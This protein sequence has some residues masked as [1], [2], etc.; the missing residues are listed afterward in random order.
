M[1]GAPRKQP[2]IISSLVMLAGANGYQVTPR[3]KDPAHSPEDKKFLPD[4]IASPFRGKNKCVFEVE[5]TVNNNTIYKSLASLLSFLVKYPNSSA[6]LVVPQKHGPF[7]LECQDNMK[8]IIRGFGKSV[9]GANPKIN[10]AVLTFEQ[11]KA[12]EEKQ[13]KWVLNGRV[14]A[15][16]K[17]KYF[18]RP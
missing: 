11:I 6:Y 4:I 5:A 3:K 17:C 16:P 18:P 14:G 10:L 13:K 1:K 15:P 9:K 8:K 12:D 2:R 7:A